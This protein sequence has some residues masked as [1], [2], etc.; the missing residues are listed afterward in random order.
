MTLFTLNYSLKHSVAN[1]LSLT[2]L[3]SILLMQ[4]AEVDSRNISNIESI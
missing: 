3:S 2:E 1:I 4:R